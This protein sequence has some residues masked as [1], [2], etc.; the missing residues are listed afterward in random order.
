MGN[1]QGGPKKTHN[2]INSVIEGSYSQY[3]VDELFDTQ[4]VYEQFD[5]SIC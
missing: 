4:F 5:E 3:I 1:G 2:P